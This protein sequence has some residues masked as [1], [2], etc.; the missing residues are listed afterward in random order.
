MKFLKL[1][2]TICLFNISNAQHFR[3]LLNK[4]RTNCYTG[5]PGNK[6]YCTKECPCDM[7]EG[8]CDSK[9]ECTGDLVCWNNVGKQINKSWNK[10]AD[11][12]LPKDWR[13]CRGK[14]YRGS[15]KYCSKKCPCYH[16]DGDCDNNDE[17]VAGTTCIHNKGNLYGFSKWTDVC[18]ETSP[19]SDPTNSPTNSPIISPTSYP[20]NSPTNSPTTSPTPC[21]T[22]S[23]TNAPRDCSSLNTGDRVIRGPDWKW[24]DQD[25]G[26]V[27]KLGTV[28]RDC[29]DY[30][31]YYGDYYGEQSN[32]WVSVQWDA[33]HNNVY[34]WNSDYRDLIKVVGVN[35]TQSP[36]SSPTQSPSSSPNMSPTQSPSSSPTGSNTT[37]LAACILDG[38][39]LGYDVYKWRACTGRNELLSIVDE[40]ATR[41][42]CRDACDTDA[43][44][45][46]FEYRAKGDQGAKDTRCALSTSC[47]Y[48]LSVSEDY[49]LYVKQTSSSPTPSPP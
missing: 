39:C 33:G 43:E 23:P 35:S 1:L 19:T 21:K 15:S 6:N 48:E 3:N 4:R 31:D 7:N 27:V 9:S 17:C 40:E 20:T 24:E 32:C 16:S 46:S 42:Q 25:D 38:P 30:G 41:Q 44:C 34:R 18:V 12:C 22:N 37:S 26:G 13:K 2:L 11:V 36:S 10:R 5:E 28:T 47:T 29:E 49:T 14:N 8:D 45:I